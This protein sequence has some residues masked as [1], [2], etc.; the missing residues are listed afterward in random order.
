[1]VRVDTWEA[2]VVSLPTQFHVPNPFCFM[3]ELSQ[4]LTFIEITLL[5]SYVALRLRSV[6]GITTR[7][8]SIALMGIV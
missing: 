2:W 3:H 6:G 4:V 5:A 7:S 8:V 1:M